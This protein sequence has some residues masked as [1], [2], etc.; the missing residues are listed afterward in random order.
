LTGSVGRRGDNRPE[1]V[2]RIQERLAALGYL[3]EGSYESGRMNA[4]TRQAIRQFQREQMPAADGRIDPGGASHLALQAQPRRAG[5]NSGCAADPGAFQ[6][7]GPR[8][9]S[10]NGTTHTL[11][12]EWAERTLFGVIANRGDSKRWIDLNSLDGGTVG[13]ANFAGGG[14]QALYRHMDTQRY[15]GREAAAIPDRPYDQQWWRDGMSQFLSSPESHRVQVEAWLDLMRPT[16]ESAVQHEAWRND[17]GLAIAAAIGN[18]SPALLQ[19]LLGEQ[20]FRTDPGA[21]LDEYVRRR[22]T[23]HRRDRRDYI[24]REFGP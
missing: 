19:D 12:P 17:R 22:P 9:I 20:R 7:A 13:I 8:T 4:A 15:F 14:L 11:T 1:D 16:L 2:A 24:I 21:A 18:S 3:G 6:A 23:E 10:R 5:E